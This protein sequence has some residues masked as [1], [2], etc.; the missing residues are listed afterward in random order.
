MF[1]RAS[2]AHPALKNG[3]SLSLSRSSSRSKPN[4]SNAC[5]HTDH[6]SM[7]T[8]ALKQ[9]ILEEYFPDECDLIGESNVE[10]IVKGTQKSIQ[11]EYGSNVTIMEVVAIVVAVV[12]FLDSL[13]AIIDSLSQ[14]FLRKPTQKEVLIEVKQTIKLPDAVDQKTLEE[15]CTHILIRIKESD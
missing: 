12:T 15:V 10:A 4:C 13:L 8:T 2:H 3:M 9:E 6:Q 14:R 1:P 7:D 5:K 11:T